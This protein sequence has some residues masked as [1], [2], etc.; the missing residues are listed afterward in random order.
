MCRNYVNGYTCTCG[1]GY[2]GDHCET[3][4]AVCSASGDPHYY[5][6]DGGDHHFQ[7]PCR[8]ILAKDC[9]N[10]NSSDFTVTTQNVPIP[11]R[12][13]VSVVREVF[14]EAHGFV[15]G[16]HQGKVV[17][18]GGVAY[19]LPFYLEGDHGWIEVSLSGQFVKILLSNF[20]VEVVYDGSHRVGVWVPSK[21]WGRMCGLCGNYNG[22]TSDDYMTPDGTIV[23]DW[24]TFGDSWLTDP[25]TCPGGP[26]PTPPPP[27]ND[28]VQA[29]AESADNCGL[30][31]NATGP[32]GVCHGTVDPEP[33][34][35]SCVF[36]MCAWNGNTIGLCQNLEAY[37]EACRA[38]GVA[39]FSWR[40]EERCPVVCPPNSHYSIC[41]SYCPAT[42]ADPY[43]EE[44]CYNRCVEGCECNPGFL[45][46][47]QECVPEEQCGC[48]DDKG[49]YYMF[50]ESWGKDGQNC[51][52]DEGNVITCVNIT[53]WSDWVDGECSVTC[54]GGT[55]IRTR[56]CDNPAPAN[57][58]AE[59]TL[60]DEDSTTGLTESVVSACNED[61]CP[62]GEVPT[63]IPTG[64][65]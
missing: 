45:L 63:V 64:S 37:V 46:S 53:G 31:T 7:G 57:G 35:T 60:E 41:T 48:T 1:S 4:M 33:F 2:E 27:C 11:S 18:V 34:F 20:S 62:T 29:A 49:R 5:P 6:F 40:T 12:P 23:G 3:A 65:P 51:V 54:G 26:Q 61:A 22:D 8:Y 42:C 13:S 24:N 10:V 39:P 56:T 25:A 19:S 30:L 43:S 59:C 16:I 28:A 52:C 9:G 14:V 21:Y 44:Y 36:D 15:V 38:A 47:G 58:G 50:G 32:F 17:T 55:Y